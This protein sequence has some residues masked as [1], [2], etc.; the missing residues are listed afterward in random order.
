VNLALTV[1]GWLDEDVIF[2]QQLGVN[3]VLAQVDLYQVV[4]PAWDPL[5]LAGLHNR[6]E[7]AGLTL[8]GISSVI[9][10]KNR[11]LQPRLKKGEALEL[12]CRLI[13]AA[14]SAGIGLVR[15]PTWLFQFPTFGSGVET[16]NPLDPAWKKLTTALQ[17][18]AET[19]TRTGVKLA[20]PVDHPLTDLLM[21]GNQEK[22]NQGMLLDL[23]ESLEN[24]YMG[25]DV[26]PELLLYFLQEHASAGLN[27]SK[28]NRHQPPWDK[29]FLVTLE[30]SEYRESK[31]IK[32]RLDAGAV[33]LIALCWRLK[34]AGYAG[35]V[36]LG[37]QPHWL[38]DSQTGHRAQSFGAG[39]LK[40]VL[41][42][43][44]KE[45]G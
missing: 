30:N 31:P 10:P 6:I 33:D 19:A 28:S 17:H 12:V 20:I 9:T 18:L 21:A 5:S 8:V 1:N 39:Y 42:A 11:G 29:L 7:K 15:P 35:L 32:A 4:S 36:R 16:L 3:Y 44:Q 26:T 40:A 23:L 43:V 2:A 22:G 27:P 41:E 38:G 13:E 34:R 37:E 25:L 45:A 24:P 14:G